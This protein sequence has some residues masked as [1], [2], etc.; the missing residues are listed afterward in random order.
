MS[1]MII[2]NNHV[3]NSS[4]NYVDDLKKCDLWYSVTRHAAHANSLMHIFEPV[5]NISAPMQGV[6]VQFC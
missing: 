6:K 1:I 5:A 3:N 2:V 4:L